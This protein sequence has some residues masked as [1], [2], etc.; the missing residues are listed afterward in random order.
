[1]LP[2]NNPDRIHIVF[3]DHRMAV[4][5]GLILLDRLTHHIHILEM[6][7]ESY[8][9]QAQPGE[10]RLASSREAGRRITHLQRRPVLLL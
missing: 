7:G 2:Q 4:N 8:L 5:A 1:M 3:D 9:P 6:N 10:R